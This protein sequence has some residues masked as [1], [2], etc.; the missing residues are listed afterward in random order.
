MT[1]LLILR[2]EPGA[3]ETVSRARTMGLDAVAAPLFS[4][5]P[6]QWVPPPPDAV[7]A[8][9]LTSA[10]AARHGGAAL[11]AFTHLPCHAVGE[12]TA[13]AALAVGFTRIQT[14]PSDG[15]ALVDAM[16]GAGVTRALH[17]CGRDHIPLD[18][19][20]VSI[21][22]RVVYAA[23]PVHLLPPEAMTALRSPAVVALHSPRAAAHFADL[24]D[25]AG[26]DR[27]SIALAAISQAAAEAAGEGWRG[28]AVAAAPR[29]AALLEL[30]EKLCQTERTGA[31]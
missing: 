19:P 16:A 15:A 21:V 13:G 1:R 23:E 6:L 10:N 8:V 25:A 31:G 30:A 17:L 11:A 29:D 5:R 24:V 22:R 12:A 27:R 28:I 18:H 20:R 14:G 2:P 26:L 9:M 7:E 3:S 4:V